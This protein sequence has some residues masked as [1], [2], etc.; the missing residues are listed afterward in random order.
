MTVEHRRQ[1][2][3]EQ[4]EEAAARAK[5]QFAEATRAR[6]RQDRKGD[7]HEVAVVKLVEWRNARE[8]LCDDVE[9]AAIQIHRC[10]SAKSLRNPDPYQVRIDSP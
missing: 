6:Q 9:E 4:R 3:E 8:E 7:V 1:R 2:G 10:C 5:D